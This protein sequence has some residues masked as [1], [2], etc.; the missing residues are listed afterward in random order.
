[1]ALR[2]EVEQDICISSGRCVADAP[3]GFR[4]DE[5]EVARAIDGAQAL[6]STRLVQIARACPSGAITVTDGDTVVDL[7]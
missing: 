5:D 4:F 7:D 6:D 1:M 3:S 2:A